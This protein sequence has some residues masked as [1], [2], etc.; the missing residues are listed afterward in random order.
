MITYEFFEYL[1][2]VFVILV[3]IIIFDVHVPVPHVDTRDC[4]DHRRDSLKMY[5]RCGQR[6]RKKVFR[7]GF[8]IDV[9]MM[10]NL[11]WN[12][13]L[14]PEMKDKWPTLIISKKE[15]Y[16]AIAFA[17]RIYRGKI[18]SLTDRN[19]RPYFNLKTMFERKF[20]LILLFNKYIDIVM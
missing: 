6:K 16:I 8:K 4:F 20:E 17:N 9:D 18:V 2:S 7:I 15:H 13:L 5:C 19:R 1:F 11:S 10:I 12:R 3:G 14:N